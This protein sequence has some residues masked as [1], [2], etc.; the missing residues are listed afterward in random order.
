MACEIQLMNTFRVEKRIGI[1]APAERIWTVLTDFAEWNQWNPHEGDVDIT[2]GFGAPVRFRE[3]IP[4]LEDRDVTA[5]LGEWEPNGQ[6]VWIEKR[7]FLF[8]STRYYEIEQL[9]PGSCIV[10]N[11]FIFAG[12]RGEGFHDKH[13]HK[14]KSAAE[15]ISERLKQRVEG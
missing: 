15:T 5:T 1:R 6:L 8:N 7:G 4:G 13:K 3:T 10:G 2:L 12:L 14:L 9:E 11:G